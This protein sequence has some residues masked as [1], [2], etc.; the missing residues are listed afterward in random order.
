MIVNPTTAQA[1]VLTDAAGL[2]AT[3]NSAS[4]AIFGLPAPA[5]L[6]Q[7]LMHL[8]A[9]HVRAECI[10]RLP[11]PP[12]Q[13]QNLA[14]EIINQAGD[15]RSAV[16]TLIPQSDAQNCPAGWV[17]SFILT[18][19]HE[20]PETLLVGQTPL[21][22]IVDAFAGTFYVVSREGHFVLWN[23][24]LERVTELTPQQLRDY[25][26]V[27]MFH[28]DDQARV[29]DGIRR[30]FDCGDEVVVEA[31]Y[32]SPT[33]RATPYLMSGTRIVCDGLP[34]LCGMGLDTSARHTQE[35]TLR[36]RERALH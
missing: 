2:I 14:V 4:E 36:L 17:A 19:D 23:A 13:L 12:G 3:W 15:T 29:A 7:P 25:D 21:A 34:Y 11:P 18:H 16:L 22:R 10:A 6:G 30:V 26:V 31:R 28:P 33:G 27:K 20:L 24:H 5:A 9:P 32:V 8:L 35:A 1:A